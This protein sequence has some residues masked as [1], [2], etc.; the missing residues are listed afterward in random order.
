MS[1]F[2]TFLIGVAMGA[3]DVVPGI[4]GGTV[5]F[6]T[7]IHGT[8]IESVRRIYPSLL[9]KCREGKKFSLLEYINAKF[10]VFLLSGMLVSSASLAKLVIWL[11]TDFPVLTWSFFFGLTLISSLSLLTQVGKLDTIL[12]TGLV[13]GT[14]LCYFITMIYPLQLEATPL[15][16]IFSGS[17]AVCAMILPGISGSFIL[18]MMGMYTTIL[19]SIRNGDFLTVGLFG[20]GCAFGL[21]AFS[22]LLSQL[23]KYARRITF[24]TLTGLMIGMLPSM[25][26]WKNLG[27]ISRHPPLGRLGLAPQCNLSPFEYEKVTSQPSYLFAAVSLMLLAILLFILLEKLA[28][29]QFRNIG[30]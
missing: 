4:S 29:R 3:A 22:Y 15:N 28:K 10:L 2:I 16:I 12:F 7:G 17:I 13:A 20:I 24:I 5:A 11:L 1:Y 30:F 27:G 26:P 21:L 25:W 14:L 23:L 9:R 19:S 18:L 8:L 6:V